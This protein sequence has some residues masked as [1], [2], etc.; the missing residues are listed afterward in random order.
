MW[1]VYKFTYIA[2]CVCSVHVEYMHEIGHRYSQQQSIQRRL[3][4][5][6]L[7][8]RLSH[9]HKF[10]ARVPS[11][12]SPR[13]T[14][15]LLLLHTHI[16]AHNS[17]VIAR[18]STPTSQPPTPFPHPPSGYA[19]IPFWFKGYINETVHESIC[20]CLCFANATV[21]RVL[22]Q[23]TWGYALR[24]RY[25]WS[26]VWRMGYTCTQAIP[27]MAAHSTFWPR[28]AIA[29][30]WRRRRMSRRRGRRKGKTTI[31]NVMEKRARGFYIG[32]HFYSFKR[33]CLMSRFNDFG[34]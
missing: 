28:K 3:N 1:D 34:L 6:S 8:L 26:S 4:M 25:H 14:S 13:H 24:I 17:P 7:A 12:L 31:D 15:T 27:P 33:F 2:I 23:W 30:T 18:T 32:E 21:Y 29:S 9:I 19:C 16:T 10:K 5:P 20:L 11:Q 22:D